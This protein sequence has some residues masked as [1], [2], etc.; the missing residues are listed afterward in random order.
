[1]LAYNIRLEQQRTPAGTYSYVTTPPIEQL[2]SF[3]QESAFATG[4]YVPR[5][6]ED[7]EVTMVESHAQALSYAVKQLIAQELTAAMIRRDTDAV[8]RRIEKSAW[9]WG[10]RYNLSLIN[11]YGLLFHQTRPADTLAKARRN[12]CEGNQTEV[13]AWTFCRCFSELT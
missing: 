10:G 8:G 11:G 6:T 1:M 4:V 5:R 13:C 3:P 12:S 7:H 9:C 2:A